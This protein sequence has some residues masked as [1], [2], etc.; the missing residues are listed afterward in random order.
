MQGQAIFEV[1]EVTAKHKDWRLTL[2]E[3]TF[4]VDQDKGRASILMSSPTYNLIEMNGEFEKNGQEWML[5]CSPQSTHILG[6]SLAKFQLCFNAMGG[7]KDFDIEG[8]ASALS[9]YG[10]K[11]RLNHKGFL[12]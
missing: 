4:H 3:F 11:S 6:A 9:L 12:L 2:Q 10:I 8:K 7:L 5:Q 1:D